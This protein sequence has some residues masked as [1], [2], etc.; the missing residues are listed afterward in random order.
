MR[1]FLCSQDDGGR[2]YDI[3]GEKYTIPAFLVKTLIAWN[4]VPENCESEI[5]DKKFVETLLV[6]V[7]GKNNLIDGNIDRKLLRFVRDLY[8]FRVKNEDRLKKFEGYCE[9]KRQAL[10]ASNVRK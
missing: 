9:N 2:I 8:R 5:I 4:T 6:C 3:D 1:D 7:I 10:K